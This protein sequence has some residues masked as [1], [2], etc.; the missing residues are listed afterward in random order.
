MF[1]RFADFFSSDKGKAQ[2]SQA[3]KSD[4]FE[5]PI[6]DYFNES[7]NSSPYFLPEKRKLTINHLMGTR[8]LNESGDPLSAE[9]K[10]ALGFNPRIKL[11]NELLATLTNEGRQLKDPRKALEEI[12]YEATLNKS[13]TDNFYKAVKAGATSFKLCASGDGS[14]CEWCRAS[15]QKVFGVEILDEFN[16]H[17]T[18]SPYSKCFITAAKLSWEE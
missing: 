15:D 16:R 12:Y 9:Q 2:A 17:C 10:K 4:Y 5:R 1:K 13:R 8:N 11:T 7:L 14:E 18:C 3:Q 6:E